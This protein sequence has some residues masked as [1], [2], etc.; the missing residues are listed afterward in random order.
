MVG[1]NKMIKLHEKLFVAGHTEKA[2]VGDMLKIL[3][4]EE[5]SYVLNV[6]SICDYDLEQAANSIGIIYS[7]TPISPQTFRHPFDVKLIKKLIH[8][9]VSY[10]KFHKILIH[11]GLGKN[12]SMLI[13]IPVLVLISKKRARDVVY[14][15]KKIKPGVLNNNIFENFV[16]NEDNYQFGQD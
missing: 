11:C 9:I 1:K 5:I 10:T 12:R 6:S 15:M 13:A 3:T 14:E 16:L 4:G 7:H 8:R 2:D